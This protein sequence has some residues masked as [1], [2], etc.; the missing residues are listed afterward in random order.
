MEKKSFSFSILPLTNSVLLLQLH[1]TY[2]G[3]ECCI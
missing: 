3:N 1:K 2:H